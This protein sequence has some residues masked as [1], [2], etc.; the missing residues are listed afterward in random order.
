MGKKRVVFA[1][2]RGGGFFTFS[3]VL[4]CF[5][6]AFDQTARKYSLVQIKKVHEPSALRCQCQMTE[7]YCNVTA[8]VIVRG[9]SYSEA[10][11]HAA[12]SLWRW[13]SFREHVQSN[14]DGSDPFMLKDGSCSAVDAT[15]GRKGLRGA[16]ENT[17]QH[18]YSLCAHYSPVSPSPSPLPLSSSFSCIPM[19]N[20]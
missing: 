15:V 20:F 9:E 8:K 13:L 14:Q 10:R 4:F 2:F 6:F 16:E 3:T 1:S 19:F 11:E 18:V 5:C 17:I 12:I 7:I